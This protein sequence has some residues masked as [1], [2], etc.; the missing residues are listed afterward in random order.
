METL[1]A[2]LAR[3]MA[4]ADQVHAVEQGK[5]LAEAACRLDSAPRSVAQ[6]APV[7]IAKSK[8]AR[9]CRHPGRIIGRCA[10]C[11]RRQK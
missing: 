5:R 11:P 8:P 7:K 10:N 1:D 9:P 6:A 3:L 4:E 2:R